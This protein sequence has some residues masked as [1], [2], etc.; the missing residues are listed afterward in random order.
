MY[1]YAKS[2]QELKQGNLM[3][4]IFTSDYKIYNVIAHGELCHCAVVRKIV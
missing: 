3:K 4:T 1:V 2:E